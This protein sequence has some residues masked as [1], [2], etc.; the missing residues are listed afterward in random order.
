MATGFP[1]YGNKES[2][3]VFMLEDVGK[4]N[5]SHKAWLLIHKCVYNV[6]C[7][8]EEHPGGEEVL[9]EQAGRD[10]AESLHDVD[11]STDTREMLKHY[12]I[13]EIHSDDCKNK[14]GQRSKCERVHACNMWNS[15]SLHL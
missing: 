5:S 10:A 4:Q 3:L 8:L 2:G 12:Y 7:F 11:H 6:T 9:L 13:G 15:G 14:K 1:L